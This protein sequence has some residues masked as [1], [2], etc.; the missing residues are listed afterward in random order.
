MI[1]TRLSYEYQ[2]TWVALNWHMDLP[3]PQTHPDFPLWKLK[4][5]PQDVYDAFFPRNFRFIGNPDRPS[6]CGCFGLREERLWRFEFVVDRAE[7]PQEMASYE[8]TK[9][10]IFPYITHAGHVYG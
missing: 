2:E 10:I 3:T 6:V 1:I 7:D 4:Y 5:T 8:K 9:E